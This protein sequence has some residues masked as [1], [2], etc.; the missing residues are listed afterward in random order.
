MIAFSLYSSL[1]AAAAAEAAP[2]SPGGHLWG[3]AAPLEEARDHEVSA[4]AAGWLLLLPPAKQGR[5]ERNLSYSQHA[6]QA[7]KH[8]HCKDQHCT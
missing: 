8:C 1:G 5:A 4:G 3:L 7:T 2:G 6:T